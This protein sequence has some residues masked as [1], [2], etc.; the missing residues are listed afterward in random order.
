MS[1]TVWLTV[2]AVDI[3]TFSSIECVCV[4]AC[5]C[6]RACVRAHVCMC[7][8]YMSHYDDQWYFCVNIC[9]HLFLSLCVSSI[10]LSLFPDDETSSDVLNCLTNQLVNIV[11]YKSYITRWI[12]GSALFLPSW[13]IIWFT[14]LQLR[15]F[16]SG[17]KWVHFCMF[18]LCVIQGVPGGMW[19]TSGECSLC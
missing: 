19:N 9:E 18:H 15:R 11:S 3:L 4:R 14:S 7:M 16:E 12:F 5:A 10:Y 13:L 8:L 6:V 1:H 2:C 17:V